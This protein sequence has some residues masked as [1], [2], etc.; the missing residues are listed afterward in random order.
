MF[1]KQEDSGG[2]ILWLPRPPQAYPGALVL[3]ACAALVLLMAARSPSI[4]FCA[5]LAVDKEA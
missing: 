1:S 2:S 5:P 4:A 3:R